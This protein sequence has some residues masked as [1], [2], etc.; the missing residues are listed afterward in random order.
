MVSDVVALAMAYAAVRIA[1]RPPTER[2][3]FGLGRTEVL[4][5]E[6]NGVL[7]LAGALFLIVEATRRLGSSPDIDA[8]GVIVIGGIGLLVNLVSAWLVGQHAHGNVNMRGAL[9]H[10]VADALGS[11][12]VLIAGVG[13]AV[14]D[15]AW[16]DSVSSYAIA[17]LIIV[18]SVRLLRDATSVLLEAVPADL[19]VNDVRRV[20]DEQPGVEAVHHL[21]VWTTGSEQIALSAHVLLAGPL[22]LHDA[23]TR[24]TDL[25]H[26]L[27]EQFGIRH[28]TLEVEC[29]TCVDDV[30][31]ERASGGGFGHSH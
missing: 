18:G 16:L 13:I 3:T 23:Q 5:A 21:H 12:A 1:Q 8:A 27:A 17:L 26:L 9:W 15:A 31:H 20:L 22:S 24:A 29:H 11:V 7:L 19:D 30:D 28:A 25:K 14:F 6:A 2:H 4:V 10:L